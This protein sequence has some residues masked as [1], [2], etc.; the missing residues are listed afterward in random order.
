MIIELWS[1]LVCR[2]FDELEVEN[3]YNFTNKIQALI[4]GQ[5]PNAG[6]GAQ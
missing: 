4:L 6:I 2:K 1:Q 3:P 5:A